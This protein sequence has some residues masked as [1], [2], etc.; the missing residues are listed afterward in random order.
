MPWFFNDSIAGIKSHRKKAIIVIIFNNNNTHPKPNSSAC[1]ICTNFQLSQFSV[2]NCGNRCRDSFASTSSSSSSFSFSP[3]L[4]SF[5]LSSSLLLPWLSPFFSFLFYTFFFCIVWSFY[6]H[7]THTF[8]HIQSERNQQTNHQTIFISRWSFPNY[9]MCILFLL[10]VCVLFRFSALWKI[11]VFCV[12]SITFLILFSVIFFLSYFIL[13]HSLF[14]ACSHF[15]IVFFFG[16][17]F[18]GQ[19]YRRYRI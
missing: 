16:C 2:S 14:L 8:T 17:L 10:F 1:F 19:I 15:G 18:S 12:R 4:S 3:A 11:E 9:R 5:K 7:D 6:I 13:F